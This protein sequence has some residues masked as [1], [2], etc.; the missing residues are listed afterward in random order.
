[1]SEFTKGP[2]RPI[3]RTTLIDSQRGYGVRNDGGYLLFFRE[4]HKYVDQEERYEKELAESRANAH[5][6]ASAPDMYEALKRIIVNGCDV[7]DKGKIGGKSYS[8]PTVMETWV[9]ACTAVRK[10][11]GEE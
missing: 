7:A 1:M 10:A 2:W 8:I 4:P 3:F 9:M 5:L 11:E 6:I